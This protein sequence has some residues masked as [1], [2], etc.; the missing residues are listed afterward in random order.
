MAA[1]QIYKVI[2]QNRDQLFE[3]YARKVSHGALFG[4]IEVEELSFGKSSQVVVDPGAEKLAAEFSDVKRT[5]VPIHAIVR[6]DEVV[7]EGIAKVVVVEGATVTPL[8]IYT[9]GRGEN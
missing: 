5:Y 3:I 1:R 9:P 7:K 4:F 6:I 2:F 8:P